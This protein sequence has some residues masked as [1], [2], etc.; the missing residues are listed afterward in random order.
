MSQ[1]T[2]EATS[3]FINAGDVPMH[4]N[5]AGEGP[6][7]IMLHGGGPGA[8]S[9]SNFKQ[10][11]PALTQHFRCLLVDLPGYGKSDKSLFETPIWD[12]YTDVLADMMDALGLER[13]HFAG[14]SHGGATAIKMALNHPDRVDRLVSMGG[15]A[16]TVRI[17]TPVNIYGQAGQSITGYFAEPSR[18]AMR[19]YLQRLVYDPSS[20]TDDIVEER[21]LSA[22]DPG[23]EKFM[24]HVYSA[25]ARQDKTG[26]VMDLEAWKRIDQ[27]PHRTLLTWGRDDLNPLDGTLFALQHMPDCRLYV[28][29]KCGHWVMVEHPREWEQAVLGFL[30]VV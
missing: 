23:H 3:R 13:A 29:P 15:G 6:P 5:E 8:T 9:W 17:L 27:I 10:N 30:S 28:F 4:Y 25:W 19:A 20:V 22:A 7:L 26:P 18:D 11:L 21:F 16:L 1:F 2:E 14:N 12:Y 24:K